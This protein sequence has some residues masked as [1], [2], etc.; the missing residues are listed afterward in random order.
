MELTQCGITDTCSTTLCRQS[1]CT[2]T[3]PVNHLHLFCPLSVAGTRQMPI[4]LLTNFFEI[5]AFSSLH[6]PH[7]PDGCSWQSLKDKDNLHGR[8]FGSKVCP[9]VSLLTKNNSSVAHF[10]HRTAPLAEK[11]AGCRLAND[12]LCVYL[13]HK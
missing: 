10:P 13:V 11:S 3:L 6:Y 12:T 9:C 8:F 5:Y 4:F 1:L 2:T 7:L